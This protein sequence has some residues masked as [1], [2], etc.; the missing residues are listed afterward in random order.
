MACKIEKIN[1]KELESL[2]A[3]YGAT[4]G[5]KRFLNKDEGVKEGVDFVFEQNPELSEIGNQQQYSKYLDTIFPDSKVRD[6]V[7]HGTGE[8]FETF[9]KKRTYFAKELEY[10]KSFPDWQTKGKKENKRIINAIVNI[11]NLRNVNKY[12]DNA[13]IEPTDRNIL[14]FSNSANFE[15]QSREEGFD[16]LEVS[17][18]NMDEIVVFE[19]EQIHILGGKQDI[20]NFKKFVNKENT[21]NLLSENKSKQEILKAIDQWKLLAKTEGLKTDVNSHIFSDLNEVLVRATLKNYKNLKITKEKN[22]NGLYT[23]T[24]YNPD[25]KYFSVAKRG[26][27]GQLSVKEIIKAQEEKI[28]RE[29]EID[30]MAG[31]LGPD[32]RKTAKLNKKIAAVDEMIQRH[33]MLVD[34]LNKKIAK[35]GYKSEEASKIR[36]KI[37]S[38]KKQ[39]DTIEKE[40]KIENVLLSGI[41]QYNQVKN[42][43]NNTTRTLNDENLTSDQIV[44]IINGLYDVDTYISIWQDIDEV[45]G[46]DL[47]SDE[48]IK[49]KFSSL[50]GA[51][52]EKH[53]AVT[54]LLKTAIVKYANINSYRE[55]FTEEELFSSVK[56]IGWMDKMFQG[57]SHSDTELVRV[58]NDIIRTAIYDTNQEY[59]TK[60]KAITNAVTKVKKE[61]GLP[62]KE[63][64]E[65][66]LQKRKDGSK[67]GDL[68]TKYSQEY[69]D[70][71]I[72]L[73]EKRKSGKI[74]Y[75]QW[76]NET[77]KI[78]YK[79]TQEILD[80]NDTTHFTEK[81]LK[82]Q[83]ELLA[84]YEQDSA[85]KLQELE[86]S[87][88]YTS[89][90]GEI[91]DR[92]A[93]NNAHEQW[94]LEN[95]PV[96]YWENEKNK[97]YKKLKK[98]ALQYIVMPIGKE[99]FF[100]KDYLDMM[101]NPALKE[102]YEFIIDTLH[103]NNRY[104][105]ETENT[106]RHNYLPESSQT[107]IERLKNEGALKTIKGLNKD[108]ISIIA[109]EDPGD[110][111]NRVI[112]GGKVIKD[113]PIRMMN[114]R[115]KPSDK[116][117]D[118]ESVLLAHTAMALNYKHKSKIESVIQ[119][120]QLLLNEMTEIALNHSG[121]NVKVN[122]FG[123]KVDLGKRLQNTK[124][125]LAFTI[126]S[127][128]YEDARDRK[129]T[130]Q[131]SSF[132]SKDDK[133]KIKELDEKLKENEIT[134][135]QYNIEKN[136]LGV[137]ISGEQI[138]DS[139][140]KLTYLKAMSL[141]NFITPT[142]NLFFG[143]MTNFM[144]SA[145]GVD[146]NDG[147]LFKALGVMLK[148]IS[149]KVGDKLHDKQIE[150]VW[151]W[152][153][154][155]NLIG[156][157][158]ESAYGK[159][160]TLLDKTTILQE[161]SELVNQ[162]SVMVA[163]LM[164]LQITDLQG[165]KVSLWNAYK[166]TDGRLEWDTERFGEEPPRNN[167]KIID[168]NMVNLM[169]L[170]N[171]IVGVVE[172]LHGDYK[173]PMYAKRD[174]IGRL[175]MLFK[176]WLPAT[177]RERFGALDYDQDLDRYF[178]GRWRS[179]YDVT[180][181]DDKNISNMSAITNFLKVIL[182]QNPLLKGQRD[183]I[184]E[185]YSDVDMQNIK[186]AAREA[187][188]ILAMSML[189]L[190]LKS[191]KSDDDDEKRGLNLLINTLGKTQADMMFFFN[192]RSM[193]GI[194]SNPVPALK[195]FTQFLDIIPITY[196]TIIGNGYYEAG[197]WKDH[198]KGEKWLY[199][200]LPI[201]GPGIVKTISLANRTYDYN[202]QGN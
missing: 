39:I 155:M 198:L 11:Q 159:R 101:N 9:N 51:Y 41:S 21:A 140:I 186:R 98:G 133:V 94:M 24:I 17:V 189:V 161:K 6:I 38:L 185:N 193:A 58:A 68:I 128:M 115:L 114:G 154:E 70:K 131:N 137:K 168:G 127:Y 50:T 153:D 43:I 46:I 34:L 5:L 182:T 116:S 47:F 36:V 107:F 172:G 183:K 88:E 184:L 120:Q 100:D 181:K 64:F 146:F 166:I 56:D 118:L 152:L 49:E 26:E 109:I 151:A 66:L 76:I 69:Y 141:P 86:D 202:G 16:G 179:I 79:M 90:D 7:Y 111:D 148:S 190:M 78:Q 147:Q 171:K 197:P 89:M 3:Q 62:E 22:Q 144:H 136:K 156:Q 40:G 108:L 27:F 117:Y 13:G 2:V 53:L 129:F 201:A 52:R 1:N 91:V 121:N 31:L 130:S 45:Y 33:K 113:I 112:I 84:Q 196:S 4:D 191:L 180:N 177:M 162:G 8:V 14:S 32:R 150:K 102:F 77:D 163:M 125:H 149:R 170:S 138:G 87:G 55:D 135:E 80:N 37:D 82:L 23:I 65:K 30:D 61:T 192:P 29:K 54:R 25:T 44:N 28:K 200:N 158:N 173:Q 35:V 103:E 126:D 187:H 67:T 42:I 110:M 85:A 157:I 81:E 134:Q 75:T 106:R 12:I 93:I 143:V 63:I 59:L 139:A 174:I 132:F 97:D 96:K 119:A 105:P 124:D 199:N 164:N 160:L 71:L 175:I 92:A 95:S 20:E 99:Q 188:I 195:T 194:T 10:A 83:R 178:K 48:G 57:A 104:L 15:K 122:K 18:K 165:K 142:V 123:H 72:E 19:P 176:T 73:K 145:G 60:S 167:S 74:T 169:R